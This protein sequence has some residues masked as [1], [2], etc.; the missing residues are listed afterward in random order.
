MSLSAQ[1]P[2][3]LIAVPLGFAALCPLLG[4]WRR[5]LCFWWA[6]LG[7]V[8]TAFFTWS[9]IGKVTYRLPLTY[10]L[11]DWS[12]PWGIRIRV[13]VPALLV[14]CAITAAVVLLVIYSYRLGERGGQTYVHKSYFYTLILLGTAGMLA[15]LMSDDIFNMLVFLEIAGIAAVGT[16]AISGRTDALRAAFRYLLAL[17]AASVLFILAVGLLY[18]VTGT[19]DMRQM[20]LQIAGM[21]SG[22]VPVAIVAL[23]VF[24]LVLAVESAL[25]PASWW[26]TDVAAT[27]DESSG[28]FLAALVTVIGTFAMFRILYSVFAP[29]LA[30]MDLARTVTS[31]TLAWIGIVAFVVGAV[32]AAFQSDL[33]GLAAYSAVSQVGLIVAAFAASA[34]AT[35]AG[36]LYAAV[37]GICGIS[38]FFLAAGALAHGRASSRISDLRGVGRQRP[39]A[40]A[41]LTLGAISFVGL[42]FTAGFA[43]KRLIIDGLIDKGWYVPVA[44]VFL[45]SLVAL[46]YCGRVAYVL[47]ARGESDVSKSEARALAT[48]ALSAAVLGISG[49]VLGVLSYVITPTLIQVAHKLILG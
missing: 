34:P 31:T 9:L 13:D 27:G 29:S 28:A 42:P 36:G 4:L 30:R 45:G 41:A 6:L 20:S 46:V 35:L 25:F 16:V 11:G 26:L 48:M 5:Q 32:I 38:C 47:F 8:A 17:A 39:V 40:A 23:V 2:V 22:Y 18:S 7:S 14:G 21:K 49:I 15:V 24:L 19:L 12:P 33:K 3:L 44:L 1:H 10:N 43:A 37:A